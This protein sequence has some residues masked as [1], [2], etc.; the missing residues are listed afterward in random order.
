MSFA[1]AIEI[2]IDGNVRNYTDSY[3]N[4]EINGEK[5]STNIPCISIDG[6]AY[7]PIRELFGDHI[8]AQ[9]EWEADKGI[10]PANYNG[11]KIG[12]SINDGHIYL[13]GCVTNLDYPVVKYKNSVFLY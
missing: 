11:K 3:F 1:S 13:D 4:I 7:A 12:V 10:A 9:I 2:E 8:G 5:V 6:S